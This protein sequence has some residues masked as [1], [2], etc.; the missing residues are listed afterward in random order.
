MQ[1]VNF[2]RIMLNDFLPIQILCFLLNKILTIPFFLRTRVN[3]DCH[4]FYY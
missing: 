4:L 3:N 2:Q 1:L